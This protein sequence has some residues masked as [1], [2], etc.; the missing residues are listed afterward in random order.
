ML[1]KSLV[2][3]W[4]YEENGPMMADWIRVMK[5]LVLV[6]AALKA[7]SQE[8]YGGLRFYI[9]TVYMYLSCVWSCL[10]ISSLI[11]VN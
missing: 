3:N 11:Q 8:V 7:T 4:T 9:C 6:Y 5:I 1:E 10:L 2:V